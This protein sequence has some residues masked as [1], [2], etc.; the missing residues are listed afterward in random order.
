MMK[1]PAGMKKSNTRST[2]GAEKQEK[3]DETC[4][5]NEPNKTPIMKRPAC[6]DKKP[7]EED[8]PREEEDEEMRKRR[9]RRS[10][11]RRCKRKMRKRRKRRKRRRLSL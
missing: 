4:V 9:K 11:K 8:A 6:A 3:E 2:R 1:K 5:K 7:D 10:V